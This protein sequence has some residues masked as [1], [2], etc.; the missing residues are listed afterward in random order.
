MD[1]SGWSRGRVLVREG[2][3]VRRKEGGM[4]VEGEEGGGHTRLREREGLGRGEED[5]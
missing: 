1:R 3:R 2:W 5:T 4:E